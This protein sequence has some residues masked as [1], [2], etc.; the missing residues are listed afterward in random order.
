LNGL[1]GTITDKAELLSLPIDKVY[2]LMEG[3]I[4]QFSFKMLATIARKAGVTAKP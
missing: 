2:D 1:S 3:R 4:Q